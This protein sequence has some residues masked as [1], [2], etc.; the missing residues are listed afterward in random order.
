MPS[1]GTASRS[2]R[3]NAALYDTGSSGA[4]AGPGE[5]FGGGLRVM[6][7]GGAARIC[8][9]R[10]FA[11]NDICPPCRS[12]GTNKASIRDVFTT[13]LACWS[14]GRLSNR[15]RSSSLRGEFTPV[16]CGLLFALSRA[17]TNQLYGIRRRA[18]RFS[19]TA[20]LCFLSARAASSV[21]ISV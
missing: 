1:C 20:A 21:R 8:T 14:G 19:S 10:C 17:I 5:F 4:G 6:G 7:G 18:I 11:H 16:I 3:G 12:R 13:A 15:T 9:A 2:F